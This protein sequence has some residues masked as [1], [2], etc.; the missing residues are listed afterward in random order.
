MVRV[1]VDIESTGLEGSQLLELAVVVASLDLDV[2]WQGTWLWPQT[3][4][5]E[6]LYESAYKPTERNP[7]LVQ[8][9]HTKNGLW[10]DLDSTWDPLADPEVGRA[11]IEQEILHALSKHGVG[12]N[13]RVP[14]CGYNPGFDLGFLKADLPEVAKCFSHQKID[15]RSVEL[16]VTGWGGAKYR[17]PDHPHRALADALD[18]VE[19]LRYYRQFIVV[20]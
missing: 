4:G 3:E 11:G 20:G 13:A 8:D 2:L 7:T 19:A 17:S 16:L 18:E 10:G 1:F 15:V 9:M 6:A 5:T 14:I 12:P